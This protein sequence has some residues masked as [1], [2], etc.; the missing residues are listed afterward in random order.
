MRIRNLSIVSIMTATA[1]SSP[2]LL[3]SEHAETPAYQYG[4]RLNI[5]KVIRIEE[6][7]PPTCEIVQAL[8]TFVSTQGVTEQISFLKQSEACRRI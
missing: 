8:M 3:A 6:P 4:T 7:T 1:L 2:S 5:A